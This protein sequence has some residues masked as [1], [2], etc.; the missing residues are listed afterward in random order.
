MLCVLVTASLAADD[1]PD[2]SGV[3]ES[4]AWSTEGWPLE[5]PFTAAGRAAQQDWEANPD[6]DP[7]LRCYIPLGRIISAPMPHEVLQ[8]E[9]RM[10]FLYEYEHQVRRVFMDGRGHPDSYPTLM[11]HSIG[12]WDGDTLVVETVG[13]E[14]GLFR[15][16]GFPYTGDLKLTERY[17]LTDGGARMIAEFIIDDPE[18][19]AETWSVRKSYRRTDG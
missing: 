4:E 10:T 14:P 2:F 13:M 19:Y 6:D 7:S 11:G 1:R 5:P 16:Q 12:H 3:W 18:Y 17:T 8:Q 15:P 9:D